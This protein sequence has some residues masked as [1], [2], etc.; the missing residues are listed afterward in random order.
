M[1]T[2][3]EYFYYLLLL[4]PCEI[5]VFRPYYSGFAKLKTPLSEFD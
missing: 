1:V 5:V 4:L 3:L 2:I